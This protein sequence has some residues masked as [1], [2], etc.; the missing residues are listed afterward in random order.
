MEENKKENLLKR[1]GIL[2]AII[3]I[4]Q[5]LLILLN[6]KKK[7][8]KG[9][10]EFAIAIRERESSNNYQIVNVYGYLGAYQF[11]MARLCDLGYTERKAGTT[12]YSNP[13][14]QWRAG[15]SK[16]YFL[17]NPDFQDRIFKQHCQDLIKRIKASLSDYL[18]KP[19]NGTEI[20]L[21][22][23]VAGAHLG[24]MG[25]ISN[26]LKGLCD[27]NDAMG[28]KVSDYIKAFAGYNLEDL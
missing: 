15:Y 21:S 24:G 3:E 7:Q 1:I 14:F 6:L 23:L 12:G 9:F 22:G 18:G 13:A 8:E 20:T 5:K 16:E 2:K 19:I 25:G 4:L 28:T 26:Y 17:N 27:S 11:G 10:E